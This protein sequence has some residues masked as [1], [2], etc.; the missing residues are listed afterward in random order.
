MLNVSHKQACVSKQG[1]LNVRHN[2]LAVQ[3]FGHLQP[4]NSLASAMA[5]PSTALKSGQPVTT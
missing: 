2:L 1:A 3:G 4:R 5:S